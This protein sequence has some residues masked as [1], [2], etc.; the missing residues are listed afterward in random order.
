MAKAADPTRARGY[1]LAAKSYFVLK[2][3]DKAIPL[4][5]KACSIAPGDPDAHYSL[6]LALRQRPSVPHNLLARTH[7]LAAVRADPN[8]APALYQLG[9]LYMER[10]EWDNALNAFQAAYD[11]RFE[12]GNLLWKAAQAS[13]SKGDVSGEAFF[14][15][16]YHEYVGEL[17]KALK[18]F[19][20]LLSYPKYGKIGHS[21]IARV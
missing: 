21:F 8:H 3:G 2:Q 1:M 19:T 10:T 9:L 5:Q 7:L 17:P 6:A 18:N 4:L 15:G 16:Q 14:L 11:L 20:S 13:K 12:P